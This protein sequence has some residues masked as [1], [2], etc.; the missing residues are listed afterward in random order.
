M[1][2]RA[3]KPRINLIGKE[4]P[5]GVVESICAPRRWKVRCKHCGELHSQDSREIKNWAHSR[6]CVKFKP[7]NWSGLDKWDSI[8]R[9][10]YGIT[11]AQYEDMLAAQGGRCFICGKSEEQEG[12]RLAIDHCHDTKI[13]R[14]LLCGVCNQ[15]IGMFKHDPVLI[16]RAKLY[17]QSPPFKF[18]NAR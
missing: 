2:K 12:R 11:L 14:G 13:V 6:E 5:H 8:I 4:T 16:D 18:A 15:G 10:V 3:R 9:R 7:H 17:C 1:T